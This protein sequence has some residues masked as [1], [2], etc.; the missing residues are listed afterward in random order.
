MELTLKQL[1]G[2]TVLADEENR[3]TFPYETEDEKKTTDSFLEN[4]YKENEEKWEK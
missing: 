4:Y 1:Y 3:N 2:K